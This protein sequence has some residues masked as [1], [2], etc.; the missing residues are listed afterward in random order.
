MLALFFTFLINCCCA[1]L[2]SSVSDWFVYLGG[3]S[4]GQETWFYV[5]AAQSA[6]STLKSII[7]SLPPV[8]HPFP[9][10]P[11]SSTTPLKK[12][13][14][15]CLTARRMCVCVCVCCLLARGYSQT[16]ACP[17]D[18]LSTLQNLLSPSITS[19]SSNQLKCPN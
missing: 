5:L 7:N 8:S 12:A 18:P 3:S 4:M 14:G 16:H 9:G 15:T 19:S 2:N 11:L 10:L 17:Q 13:S 6:L 1:L